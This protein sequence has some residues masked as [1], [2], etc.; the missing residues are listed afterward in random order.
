MSKKND[1]TQQQNMEGRLAGWQK[2][3]NHSQSDHG[4]DRTCNL[5]IPI[6]A[7]AN[8]SQAPCH[9]ATRPTLK[10]YDQQALMR[11]SLL[12]LLLLLRTRTTII[13]NMTMHLVL[14]YDATA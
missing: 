3:N 4:R 9:W 14:L 2:K 10:R 12:L 7:I 6:V 8:R 13:R 11:L 5:L 1:S